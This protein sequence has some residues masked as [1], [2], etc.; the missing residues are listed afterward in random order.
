MHFPMNKLFSLTILIALIS[1]S[2]F[3]Q[4]EVED[5]V[6][7]NQVAIDHIQN[8][9]I[10]ELLEQYSRD[11]EQMH[12]MVRT[13]SAAT[14]AAL[15]G[16]NQEA[17][18]S[19]R[20]LVTN[21]SDELPAPFIAD[22]LYNAA[23]CYQSEGNYA[24][25]ANM[26]DNI[27]QMMN[28]YEDVPEQYRNKIENESRQFHAMAQLPPMEIEQKSDGWNIPF[29]ID[30]IGNPQHRGI[31]MQIDGMLNGKQANIVFDTGCAICCIDK[32]AAEEY[33]I[34]PLEVSV[35]MNAAAAVNCQLAL[36]EDLVIGDLALRNVLFVIMDMRTGNT[37][38]DQY[39]DKF[40]III[41]DNV[42]ARM[43]EVTVDFEQLMIHFPAEPRNF[44]Q[45]N[46]MR[47][48]ADK[49][50]FVRAMVNDEPVDMMIDTGFTHFAHLS[51]DYYDKHQQQLASAKRIQDRAAG[52]GGAFVVE[53]C[54][55]T[56]QSVMIDGTPVILDEILVST[57]PADP[58]VVIEN[59][60]IGIMALQKMGKFSISFKDA[61][62]TV[63]K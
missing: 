15:F 44:T 12:P 5:E 54:Q 58:S 62:M 38:A 14:L 19:I 63:G 39:I 31:Y 24:G 17:I 3:A 33:G 29:V 52:M 27:L 1:T 7:L 47:S 53:K 36:V 41:G 30:S 50:Y 51:F 22:Y 48:V 20:S 59:N 21:Y 57:V 37:E 4:E 6:N 49:T 25:A 60:I 10:Y 26:M 35:D 8:G 2:S 13:L 32:S 34:Q 23:V 9:Q 18:D 11:K 56:D 55:L 42:I 45:R 46:V 16:Q 40:K 43:Q 28:Q 61:Y